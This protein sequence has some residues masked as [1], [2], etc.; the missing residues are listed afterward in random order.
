MRDDFRITIPE[1]DVAADTLVEAGALGAR[2]TG[3]GFGGC[4]IGLVPKDLVESAVV[5]VAEAYDRHR[6]RPPAAFRAAPSAGA[7]RV[8]R[9][10]SY[11]GPA[12]R[13]V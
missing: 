7:H 12:G 13:T 9:E 8:T 10:A 5:A 1:L 6:F 4:V 2:M 11:P 3:G